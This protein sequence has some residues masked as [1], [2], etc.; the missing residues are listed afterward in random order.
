M[1]SMRIGLVTLAALALAGQLHATDQA[2]SVDDLQAAKD[3]VARA[4]SQSKGGPQH[5]LLMEQQQLSGMID[6]LQHGR[7]VAPED[8]DSALNRAEHGPR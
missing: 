4:A 8:I 3:K 5:L 1:V 7:A 2:A 6:D